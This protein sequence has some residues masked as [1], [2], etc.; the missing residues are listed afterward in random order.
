MLIA[1]LLMVVS[2][3]AQ[4]SVLVKE[5]TVSHEFNPTVND[6]FKMSFAPVLDQPEAYSPTFEYSFFYAPLRTE[7]AIQPIAAEST[8][9]L[10]ESTDH[11]PNYIKGGGG[12]YSTLYGELFYNAYDSEKQKVN[13]FYKNRSSWGD[14]RLQDGESKVD[15]PFFSNYGKVDFQRRYRRNVLNSAATFSRLGYKYY[16]DNTLPVGSASYSDNSTV[17][18]DKDRQSL[19][20]IGFTMGLTSLERRS[21]DVEYALDFAFNALSN[22]DHFS[23]NK[24]EI[25]GEFDKALDKLNVGLD[26]SFN[27][28]FTG[29][30]SSALARAYQSDTYFG[31]AFSPFVSFEK[32][33]WSLKAG[34]KFDLYQVEGTQKMTLAPMVDFDFNI[35]PK[36]FTGY[37]TSTGGIKQNTYAEVVNENL[38]IANDIERKPTRTL[39][40]VEAGMIGHPTKH[41]SLKLGVGYKMI[42]DQLFYVNEFVVDD[43]DSANLGAYTNR[44]VAEYD[45]NNMVTFHGEINYNTHKTWSISAAADYYQYT[46]ATMPEAWQM[47]SYK[48]SAFGHYDVTEKIKVKASFAFLPQRAVK[49]SL[50][51][52]VDHLPVTYDLS[53]SGEYKW[54]DN[55]SFFLDMNNVAASKYYYYN[56]YP[57]Y[58]FNVLAGAVFRF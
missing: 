36:Y 28:G 5:V 29:D 39:L 18:L 12:N 3:L 55:L 20:N 37:L 54:K 31:T 10:Q 50:D 25:T 4:D 33:N 9:P 58:R 41:L 44:F 1:A 27:L 11:R 43:S 34:A 51:N 57:A 26:V 30:P 8:Q 14:V 42:K 21:K 17:S 19:M 2:A 45:N 7:Y 49:I 38:F 13:L 22:D 53:L 47:P 6:A 16:G 46:L 40:D 32:K 56:G 48:I 23:E 52:G 15:A 24:F 35:V